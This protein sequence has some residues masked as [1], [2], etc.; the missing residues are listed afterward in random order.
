MGSGEAVAHRKP[1]VKCS[2]MYS[3]RG[4]GGWY[5]M[6]ERRSPCT[7]SKIEGTTKIGDVNALEA[8]LAVFAQMSSLSRRPVPHGVGA[9]P[10][11]GDRI[12]GLDWNC[13]GGGGGTLSYGAAG[14][15]G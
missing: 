6:S 2:I 4:K 11:M 5:R 12:S 15:V 9:F 3:V 14:R 8:M 13:I 10:S 1:I 7:V